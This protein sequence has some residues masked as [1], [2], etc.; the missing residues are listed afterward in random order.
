[1]E[2]IMNNKKEIIS[3]TIEV[4]FGWN[5]Y[6][7]QYSGGLFGG[8][9]YRDTII[10]CDA[11]AL[12]CGTDGRPISSNINECSI[13]YDNQSLFDAA[14]I[15]SG[16]NKN[17]GTGNAE[18]LILI[19]DKIPLQVKKIVF[20]VDLFKDQK[21]FS[22]GKIQEIYIQ[23]IDKSADKE[24]M[25]VDYNSL[26]IGTKLVSVGEIHRVDKG[27]IFI[28]DGKTY[29]LNSIEEYLSLMEKHK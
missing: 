2:N 9:Y 21:V 22:L 18:C 26:S 6:P 20:T 4:R 29:A 28:E 3:G 8:L 17:I 24:I 11:R 10:D 1:M 27:W 7:K 23:L 25:H 12:F 13:S 14:A 16:D 15:H 19:L 5:A